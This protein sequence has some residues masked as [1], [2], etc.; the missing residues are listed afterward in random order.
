MRDP[1]MGDIYFSKYCNAHFMI[2]KIVRYPKRPTR[3]FILW[4]NNK[5]GDDETDINPFRW[6]HYRWVA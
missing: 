1:Q 6:Q 3:Y 2:T 5:W 4:L